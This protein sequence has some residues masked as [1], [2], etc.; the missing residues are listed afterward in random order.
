MTPGVEIPAAGGE[1]VVLDPPD[2]CLSDAGSLANLRNGET[3][4][5]A[6]ICQGVTNAHATPPLPYRTAHRPGVREQ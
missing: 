4:L 2:D 1:I 5:A 3:R 6:R